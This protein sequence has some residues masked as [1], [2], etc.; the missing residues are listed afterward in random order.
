MFSYLLL[1]VGEMSSSQWGLL[2][3]THFNV[4]ISTLTFLASFF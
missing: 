2:G 3:P 4:A 1:I